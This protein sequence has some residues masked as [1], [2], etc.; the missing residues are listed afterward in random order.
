MQEARAVRRVT[1]S[2]VR[3]WVDRLI[4]DRKFEVRAEQVTKG[5]AGDKREPGDEGLQN[6]AEGEYMPIRERT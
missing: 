6:V 5:G 3:V 2:K 4:A 1:G